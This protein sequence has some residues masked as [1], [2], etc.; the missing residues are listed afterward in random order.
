[1][2][3][4][5]GQPSFRPPSE[6]APGAAVGPAVGVARAAAA[7]G[8]SVQVIGKVGGD[9]IGDA[10]LLELAR[11]GIGHAAILRDAGRPTPTEPSPA[12]TGSD[13]DPDADTNLL[14]LDEGDA[15]AGGS[16]P[17]GGDAR[18]EL[19]PADVELGLRYLTDYRVIV[20]AE[21][22]AAATFAIIAEAAAYAG[23]Q[24][25]LVTAPGSARPTLDPS[26]PA[27]L[28]EAPPDDSDEQFAALVGRYA[29][30]LDAGTAPNVAFR[31]ALGA[32]GWEPVSP[33]T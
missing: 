1:V 12:D 32:A 13:P 4:V 24:L 20:A 30:A 18:I 17:V 11:A 28:L 2:I 6:T 19:D 7:A 31:E 25:I 14:S 22:L 21:P 10:V 27:T 23:A 26:I 15:A 33:S 3:A 9:A 29:A 8:A 5:V 16:G